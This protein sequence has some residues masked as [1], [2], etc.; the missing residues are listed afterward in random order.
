MKVLKI[1]YAGDTIFD[2]PVEEFTWTDSAGAVTVTGK[3]RPPARAGGS[4]LELLAAGRRQQAQAAI[5]P[6]KS[7]DTDTDMD[8]EE[9]GVTPHD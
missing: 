3:T 2:G 5:V 8:A 9:T 6:D 4:L 1:T 7:D